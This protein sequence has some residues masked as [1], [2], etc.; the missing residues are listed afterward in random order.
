MCQHLAEG[1]FADLNE[2]CKQF[3]PLDESSACPLKPFGWAQNGRREEPIA[4]QALSKLS[5]RYDTAATL[6]VTEGKNGY[7]YFEIHM[8]HLPRFHPSWVRDGAG[9]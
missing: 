8:R 5:I 4:T 2:Q 1:T 6:I 9:G 7:G 3:A